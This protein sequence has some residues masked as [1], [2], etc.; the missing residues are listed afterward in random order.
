MLFLTGGESMEQA[1]GIQRQST[2]SRKTHLNGWENMLFKVIDLFKDYLY[3]II[4][5]IESNQIKFLLIYVL[6]FKD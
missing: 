6:S 4:E 5:Y 1:H 3:E 2:P